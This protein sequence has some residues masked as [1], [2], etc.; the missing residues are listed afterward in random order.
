MKIQNSEKSEKKPKIQ[1]VKKLGKIPNPM[2]KK[3]EGLLPPSV[4]R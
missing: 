4:H 3:H 2:E 1:K